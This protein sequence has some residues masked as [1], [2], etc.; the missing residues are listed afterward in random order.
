MYDTRLKNAYATGSYKVPY[1]TFKA[2]PFRDFDE[3]YVN[4]ATAANVKFEQGDYNVRI[5]S[6]AEK[7]I[8]IKQNGR[9]LQIDV[10][11][12]DYNSYNPNPYLL[13]IS[14]PALTAVHTGAT[15]VKQH[16]VFTDTI[17]RNALDARPVTIAGFKL[18]SLSITQDY[19]SMVVLTNN[20]IGYLNVVSGESQNSASATV[21]ESSN[22]FDSTR[23]DIQQ[24]SKLSLDAARINKWQFQIGDHAKLELSGTA[25]KFIPSFR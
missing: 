21:I 14:C 22:Q 15:Y 20:K 16:K 3:V 17:A 12:G 2:I 7:S 4:S 18:D 25:K 13:L 10:D 8:R 6:N 1:H 23:F 5:D 19:G 9:R 11:F 24:Y